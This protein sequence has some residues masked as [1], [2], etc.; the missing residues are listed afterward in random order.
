M[1]A[2]INDRA[3]AEPRGGKKSC[4]PVDQHLNSAVCLN[5]PGV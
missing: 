4:V 2:I 1:V 3:S 5:T